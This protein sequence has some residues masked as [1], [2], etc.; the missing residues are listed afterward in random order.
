M[1][2]LRKLTKFQKNYFIKMFNYNKYM[3]KK[4]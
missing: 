4:I 1:N 2:F 3:D